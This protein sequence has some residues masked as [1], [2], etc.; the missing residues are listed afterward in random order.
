MKS[1]ALAMVM[2]GCATDTTFT[3]HLMISRG[4]ATSFV[5]DGQPGEM[6]VEQT[7][8]SSDDEV[9]GELVATFA[10]GTSPSIRLSTRC[11]QHTF[12]AGGPFAYRDARC[13]Y[14]VTEHQHRFDPSGYDYGDVGPGFTGTCVCAFLDGGES[15]NDVTVV[16]ID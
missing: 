5:V 11:L 8:P 13:S 3:E 2:A 10:D 4:E 7:F 12:D 6:L 9:D 15:T 16:Q 14:T 1:I